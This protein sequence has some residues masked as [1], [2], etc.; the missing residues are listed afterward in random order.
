MYMV[1]KTIENTLKFMGEMACIEM[2]IT[3]NNFYL[4]MFQRLTV[5]EFTGYVTFEKR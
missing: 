1:P 5:G 3:L 2:D 4:D